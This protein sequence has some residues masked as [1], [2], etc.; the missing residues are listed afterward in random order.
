MFSGDEVESLPASEGGGLPRGRGPAGR[1][2]G[3][4]AGSVAVSLVVVLLLA[5]ANCVAGLVLRVEGHRFVVPSGADEIVLLAQFGARRYRKPTMYTVY[6]DGRVVISTR[7]HRWLPPHERAAVMARTDLEDLTRT[8]FESGTADCATD[9]SPRKLG[10]SATSSVLS[11]GSSGNLRVTLHLDSF[12]PPE[13]P[14]IAPFYTSISCIPAWWLAPRLEN[15]LLEP[16]QGPGAR[17]DIP[18]LPAR[19]LAD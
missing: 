7:H 9:P 19:R 16:S 13:G 8:L 11:D 6:G 10:F 1:R 4:G 5:V 15:R 17:P 3:R 12:T 2:R 18:K 14:R